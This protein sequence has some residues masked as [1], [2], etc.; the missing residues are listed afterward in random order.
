MTRTHVVDVSNLA[1]PRHLGYHS[2][3]SRAIDHN[4]YIQG[5]MIHQA[6]YAAGYNLLRIVDPAAARFEEAGFFDLFPESDDAVYNGAWSVY[7]YLPSGN[8]LVSG[9][10][11]GLFVLSRSGPSEQPSEGPSSLPS[12]PAA[13][14][15]FAIA[16]GGP[17]R[18]VRRSP[19]SSATAAVRSMGDAR[20]SE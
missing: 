1:A 19:Q 3:R 8:I 4:L 15:S 14:S 11:Q 6:N 9:I 2:G 12:A 16:P 10:E 20:V 13:H 18:G 17:S 5:D 7:P